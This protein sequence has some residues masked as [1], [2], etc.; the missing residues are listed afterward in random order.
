MLIFGKTQANDLN[1]DLKFSRSCRK[2]LNA[3]IIVVLS[4][5]ACGAFIHCQKRSP[6]IS[7][8]LT[9]SRTKKVF[10]K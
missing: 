2:L 1:D 5:R 3:I 7:M 9:I 4:L 8:T 6:S 10:I